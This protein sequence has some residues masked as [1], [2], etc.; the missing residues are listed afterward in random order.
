ME[1]SRGNQNNKTRHNKP[2]VKF[3]NSAEEVVYES[4]G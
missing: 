4:R 1:T 3:V 2:R